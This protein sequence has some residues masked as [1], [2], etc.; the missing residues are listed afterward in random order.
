MW[1]LYLGVLAVGCVVGAV[2]TE[3]SPVQPIQEIQEM[4]KRPNASRR[5]PAQIAPVELDGVRFEQV[6]DTT[7]ID[8]QDHNG[9]LR[10][11]SIASGEVLWTRQIY[12]IAYDPTKPRG[13]QRVYF[14]SLSASSDG[15]S[16]LVE[17]EAGTRFRV[18]AAT[19]QTELLE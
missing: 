2:A 15:K 10:A 4:A 8:T 9:W 12:A 3:V 18:D 17:N 19:G 11:T 1:H 7:G 6:L 14:K 16:L 5:P 13:V